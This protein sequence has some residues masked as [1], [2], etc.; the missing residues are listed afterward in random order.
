MVILTKSSTPGEVQLTFGDVTVGNKS[1][2]E[3]VQAFALV[4]GLGSPSI[5][6]FNLKMAFAPDREK[7]RLP[8]AEVLLCAVGDLACSKKQRDW[9]S[10][11]A[12]LLPPFLTEAAILR[13]ELD[14]G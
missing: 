5:I 8:I 3:S 14:A 10:L 2:G 12:V 13:G 4:G 6:S 7:I 1:L 9:P 11:N